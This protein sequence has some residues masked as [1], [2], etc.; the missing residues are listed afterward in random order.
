MNYVLVTN[1]YAG[2]GAE[3]NFRRWAR[4]LAESGD[5]V[6]V[7]VYGGGS[8]PESDITHPRER[9]TAIGARR[10]VRGVASFVRELRAIAPD[11][12]VVISSGTFAN[13]VALVARRRRSWT[14]L[15]T[16]HHSPT[17]YLDA[18]GPRGR[19]QR[20]FARRWY[21]RADGALAVSHAV[22]GELVAGFATRPSRTFVI[23]S[24]ITNGDLL[25]ISSPASIRLLV[26]GRL[27]QDKHPVRVF[28]VVDVL[29]SG[30][31]PV[32]VE[33]VGDGPLREHLEAEARRRGVAATFCGYQAPWWSQ[34]TND[35]K[36]VVL[37]LAESE[38]LCNVL[39]EAGVAG[40]P[41]VASSLA[42][43]VGDAIVDGVTGV[44]VV[45]DSPAELAKGVLA[46]HQLSERRAPA[47]IERFS[48]ARSLHDLR[49]AVE[50][51]RRSR[52][53]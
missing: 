24:P 52:R 17:Q 19:A 33:F 26:V 15:I 18:A 30:G 6:L 40:I 8:L 12:A 37:A 2:G 3:F 34:Y 9:W 51:T 43:G 23:P 4:G 36:C 42:R 11:N 20:F 38:G 46:A 29:A 14:L 13:L 7:A 53:G 5:E 16:E 45:D 27:A 48:L 41:S 21:R 10:G 22:A 28:D 47:L 31:T 44:L 39:V 1:G 32:I 49:I 35:P 25:P 50:V